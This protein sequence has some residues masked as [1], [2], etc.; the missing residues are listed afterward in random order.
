M[1]VAC[2]QAVHQLGM[3]EAR[4]PLAQAA[5]YVASAP[6]S[7]SAYN[8]INEALRVVEKEKT[9]DIPSYL[10]VCSYK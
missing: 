5:I 4:I 10:K 8:A 9:Y 3:P 2:A 1:A 7:N 6:K